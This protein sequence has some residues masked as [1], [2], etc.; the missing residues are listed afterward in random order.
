LLI[1]RGLGLA[2]FHHIALELLLED[3]QPLLREEVLLDR[4]QQQ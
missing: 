4:F 3:L 1:S 2:V